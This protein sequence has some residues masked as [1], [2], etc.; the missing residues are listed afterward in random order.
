MKLTRDPLIRFLV[1]G[2]LLFIAHG[3]WTSHISKSDK[4]LVVDTREIARQ[5]DLFSIE[6]G[7]RPTDAELQG[8]IVSYVEEE[9][10]AREAEALGL[11]EDDT[12]IRRRLAQKMRLLTDAGPIAEPDEAL[13]RDWWAERRVDYGLPERRV[14]QHIYY[15]SIDRDNA[16]GDALQAD[17]TDWEN[18]GDPFIV[19]REFGPVTFARTAQDYGSNFASEAFD[20]PI[21]IWTDPVQSPFGI[22][23]IRTTEVLPA[24]DPDFEEVRGRV[25]S[26]WMDEAR[27]ARAAQTLRDRVA[28]YDVIIEEP[29]PEAEQ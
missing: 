8:I 22:H 10:L 14:L 28:K 29:D 24:I 6:N 12:V 17:L 16:R 11:G 23:R 20:M 19:A 21:N 27:K 1:F 13:L 9:V 4:Q 25:L 5:S 7:R 15:S 3:L 26:D 18:Q 2:A